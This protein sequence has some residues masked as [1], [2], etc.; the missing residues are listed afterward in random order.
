MSIT[1]LEERVVHNNI[2]CRG[3]NFGTSDVRRSFE[4]VL[5]PGSKVISIKTGPSFVGVR[6]LVTG[7]IE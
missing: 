7:L 4:I 5:A 1:T 3:D 2:D 6:R